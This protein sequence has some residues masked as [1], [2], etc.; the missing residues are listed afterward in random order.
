MGILKKKIRFKWRLSDQ[1]QFFYYVS[2]YTANGVPLIDTL[3]LLTLTFSKKFT[4]DLQQVI[5]H[6]K[7]GEN[8]YD[9]FQRLKFDTDVVVIFEMGKENERSQLLFHKCYQILRQK[10]N[11]RQFIR[12]LYTY[13]LFLLLLVIASGIFMTQT[14]LPQYASMVPQNESVI[15]VFYF[16]IHRFFSYVPL[17]L[18]FFLLAIICIV[19][20]LPYTPASVQIFF[21]KFQLFLPSYGKVIRKFQSYFLL[22]RFLMI[23]RSHLPLIDGIQLFASSRNA[24][25]RYQA[26]RIQSGFQSG[27]NLHEIIRQIKFYDRSFELVFFHAETHGHLLKE[28]E[29]YAEILQEEIFRIVTRSLKGFQALTFLLVAIYIFVLYGAVLLPMYTLFESF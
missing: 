27:E 16:F 15:S 4:Y 23:L 25:V 2:H 6:L 18:L 1:L 12:K 3:Q 7:S 14:I 29:G 21:L 26:E 28:L 13:P 10:K 9:I 17:I 19:I 20:V 11:L 22:Q 5:E 24:L 8:L